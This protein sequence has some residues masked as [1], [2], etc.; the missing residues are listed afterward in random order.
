LPRAP[1]KDPIT[2]KYGENIMR[3]KITNLSK[4]I[5][6]LHNLLIKQ[7]KK[8]IANPLGQRLL[9]DFRREL[10]N[11]VAVTQQQQCSSAAAVQQQSSRAAEQQQVS[12]ILTDTAAV[13]NFNQEADMITEYFFDFDNSGNLL[14]VMVNQ[15]DVPMEIISSS[16]PNLKKVVRDSYRHVRHNKARDFENSAVNTRSESIQAT[17]NEVLN[18][19]NVK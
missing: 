4:V 2:A 7:G 14:V 12:Q 17:I 13:Q 8:G 9:A 18:E 1:A 11:P 6:E 16:Y 15:D 19:G 3:H 10:F 5:V